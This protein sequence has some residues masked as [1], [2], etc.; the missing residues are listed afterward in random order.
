[1]NRS[2]PALCAPSVALFAATISLGL[3]TGCADTRDALGLTN[4]PPDE[5]AVVDHPPLSMPPDFMLRPPRPGTDIERGNNPSEKAAKALYGEGT[6]ELV[7]QQGVTSLKSQ[8]LSPAEQALISQS[9]S[10]KASP[11]IRSQVN[12]ESVQGQPS[13]KLVDELLFWKKPAQ[14]GAVVD[15]QAEA[16]RLKAVKGA[17][18]PLNSGPTT[19]YERGKEATIQ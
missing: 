8:Q 18:Q 4:Q 1:M 16:A 10:D 13:R 14:P 19:A 3:L 11:T 7:P 15:A 6:M 17:G 5:F 2:R 9:G 12:N